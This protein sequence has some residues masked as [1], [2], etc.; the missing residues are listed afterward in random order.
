MTLCISKHIVRM[1]HAKM[2]TVSDIN[3]PIITAP[4]VRM[5]HGLKRNMS[6]NH[7]LQRA[8]AAIRADLSI[9]RT[10][11][12]E[13]AKDDGLAT[14][15]ASTLATHTASTKVRFINARLLRQMAR[16]VH[17]LPR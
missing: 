16:R 6:T 5:N 8:F 2:L 7:L 17:I 12:F 10:V 3:Q 11:T 9:D 1:K 14:G 15:S 4:S 13:D